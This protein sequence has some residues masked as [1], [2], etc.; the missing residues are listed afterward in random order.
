MTNATMTCDTVKIANGRAMVWEG[1]RIASPALTPAM[2][3][4]LAVTHLTVRVV[5]GATRI[6][7]FVDHGPA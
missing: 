5:R 1:Q 2:L 3:D 6:G 7:S 4:A